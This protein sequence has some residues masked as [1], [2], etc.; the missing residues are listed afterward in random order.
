MTMLI[1][2]KVLHAKARVTRQTLEV[3]MKLKLLNKPAVKSIKSSDGDIIDCV[4]IYKQPAFDHPAL[5]NHT[6][7]MK[8]SFSIA[9]ETPSTKDETKS[10]QVV[11]QIWQR[12]G[13]CP[14]GT[15]PIR[16]IRSED[17][18]RADSLERYGKKSPITYYE[19]NTTTAQANGPI[20]INNTKVALA[21]QVNRS[22]AL[23][24]TVGYNY[25]GAQGDINLWNPHVASPDEY[26]TAQIWLKAGI[27]DGFESIEAGWV[28]NPKLYGDTQTR[29]FIY[30]TLD[31]YKSTGCFDLTCT[32]FVQ[33]NPKIALGTAL[34]PISSDGGP[35]YQ[36]TVSINMDPNTS[37]W[38]LKLGDGV[39]AGYWPGTLF[40]YLKH[41]AILV[42]WGGE[43]YSPN[44]WT[45]PHPQTAMGSGEF[46]SSLHGGAC[47][48]KGVRIVD[49]SMSL[50]Y[51]ER[52]NTWA[53][54]AYCY[55][56][57]NYIEGYTVEPVLYFGGPGRNTLCP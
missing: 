21:Q 48:I 16:R 49:Y 28:V 56:A 6:I 11:Y 41:S 38:W 35:Q 33:T 19:T 8:P 17:L 22:A 55:S 20:F 45:H 23:L 31:A 7:Q 26:T 53:D 18:L 43:V 47:Y 13:S 46:A 54:Q 24:V 40:S 42:Q 10:E 2:D 5:R 27:S 57:Y 15:I 39:V 25:I 12:S 3:D 37:N 1:F 4:D 14:Q 52:V 9:S 34:G 36:F 50:K 51:P 29:L 44:M 32:G 30:W